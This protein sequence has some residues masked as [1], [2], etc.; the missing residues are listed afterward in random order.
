MIGAGLGITTLGGG[1]LAATGAG[2]KSDT[3]PFVAYRILITPLVAEDVYGTTQDITLNINATD[4]VKSFGSVKQEID[5]GDYDIGIFT[6]GNLTLNA[7][8]HSRKFND[9]D[10]ALSIFPYGR[11]RA[12]VEIT[13][14]D[15]SNNE[16][17]RFKG[18]I[19][20]DATRLDIKTDSVR[21]KVLSLDSIFRQVSVPAGA[22][23]VGDLFSTAIKKILNIPAITGTL[24]FSASNINVDLDLT[25]DAAEGFSNAVVKTS[26]DSLLRASNSILYI[27]NDE[28]VIVAPRTENPTTHELFGNGDLFGRES[29]LT[30]KNFNSGVHRVFN[31]V[32]V[33]N[34][35]VATD[36]AWV[37]ED[38]FRQ[39]S[40]SFE[41][42][43]TASKELLI[44]E[45]ISNNFRVPKKETE[46]EVKTEEVKNARILDLVKIDYNYKIT[47]DPR[48][49]KL[50]LLGHDALG[51]FNLPQTSGSFRIL[52]NIKWKIIGIT[53]N[54]KNFTTVLKLRQAGTE[55]NDGVFS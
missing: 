28:N 38:G 47:P 44:A 42:I 33:G 37:S 30:I 8:N 21:L 31:S 23:V 26:L 19:N 43:T 18:L 13:Y 48:D 54:A 9:E 35:E 55:A 25:I 50:P 2:A 39:K 53:E 34:T 15:T 32:K 7:I 40:Y 16:I 41:F 45:R 52:P 46:I 27:D 6:F 4:F 11:D 24:N 12:K 14:C 51:T 36:S 10:D 17:T 49:S 29:I 20:E 3:Y 1:A 5:N 22:I